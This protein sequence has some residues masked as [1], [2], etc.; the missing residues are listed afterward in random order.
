ML[1]GNY[2]VLD[3]V[4]H[5]FEKEPDWYWE[6]RPATVND[7]L[8]LARWMQIRNKKEFKPTMLEIAIKQVG[9]VST[10]TNIPGAGLEK[11]GSAEQFEELLKQMPTDLMWEI[12]EALGAVNPLWGPPRPQQPETETENPTEEVEIS[13]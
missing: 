1:F 5:T 11:G 3:S 12:W 7:E 10:K 2:A 8:D 4:K 6:F 9:M 13:S